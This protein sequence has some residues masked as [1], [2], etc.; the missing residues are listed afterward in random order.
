MIEQFKKALSTGVDLALKTWAE[1][2]AMGKEMIQ[3]AQLPEKEAKEFL[4]SLKKTYDHAQAKVESRI[5]RLVKDILK[6]ADIPTGDEV[7]ALRREV[8]GLKK[9]LKA[10]KAAATGKVKRPKSPS[11]GRAK[12]QPKSGS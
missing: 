11:A 7:K 5:G 9:E 4:Q 2:E 12:S 1:V 8:Q 3:K 6:K 10:A